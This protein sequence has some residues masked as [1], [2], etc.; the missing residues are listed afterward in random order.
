MTE[1]VTSMNNIIVFNSF[2]FTNLT[3]FLIAYLSIIAFTRNFFER[4]TRYVPLTRIL[5][6]GMLTFLLLIIGIWLL[7]QFYNALSQSHIS[8]EKLGNDSLITV[9]VLTSSI[10]V[11][12]F[13]ISMFLNSIK[14]IKMFLV[15]ISLKKDNIPN[16]LRH[17]LY[18]QNFESIINNYKLLKMGDEKVSLSDKEVLQLSAVLSNA[19]MYEDVQEILKIKLIKQNT[20]RDYM[21]SVFSYQQNYS[22]QCN[23]EDI[24][25]NDQL[26]TALQKHA[27]CFRY[28]YMSMFI[29]AIFQIYIPTLHLIT[30]TSP[31]I[32]GRIALLVTGIIINSAIVLK[33]IILKTIYQKSLSVSDVKIKSNN[34]DKVIFICQSLLIVTTI[35]R[36]LMS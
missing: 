30:N 11:S 29:V 26:K 17:A 6:Q 33:Y 19:G 28:V 7:S 31:T 25:Y 10:L 20:F 1:R 36:L 22:V 3:L 23:A 15:F 9:I 18:K 35:I 4:D 27:M 13:I 21:F 12:I 5:K 8:L 14:T 16:N 24:S 2:V 34:I 32:R